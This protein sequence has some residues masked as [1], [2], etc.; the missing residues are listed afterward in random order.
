MIHSETKWQI[1]LDILM[2]PVMYILQG[3]LSD[4]PQRTHYWNYT[5]VSEA[6][7]LS[8]LDSEKLL[9]LPGDDFASRRWLLGLP[10]LHMPIMGGWRR[11]YVLEPE[12]DS[13]DEWFIGW[14][15]GKY[16]GVSHV[17]IRGP[18]RMLKDKRPVSFFG[19]K[20]E[21]KQIRI[22]LIGEG[23]LGESPQYGRLPLL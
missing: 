22:R 1:F 17:P 3:N 4:R 2:M 12:E 23:S 19:F 8:R 18:V 14:V 7:L 5:R 6:E 10:L 16:S 15:V 11:Y 20:S 13:A 9:K 21:E